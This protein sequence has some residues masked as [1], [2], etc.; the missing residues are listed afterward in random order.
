M[1]NYFSYPTEAGE[2]RNFGWKRDLA[3]RKEHLR[4]FGINASLTVIKSVDLRDHMPPIYD[5]GD[6]LALALAHVGTV[7]LA[8]AAS[9]VVA[10]GLAI[11][12]TRASGA[13]FL[14]LSRTLV[15]ANDQ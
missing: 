5:Q 9:T 2:E 11:L 6:L 15:N 14:P 10:V 1:G 3:D 12:V 4:V 13:Q 8:A 7:L